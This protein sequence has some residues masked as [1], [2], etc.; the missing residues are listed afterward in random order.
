[1]LQRATRRYAMHQLWASL[2]VGE[3]GVAVP[4]RVEPPDGATLEEVAVDDGIVSLEL[5]YFI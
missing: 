2:H 3:L 1:M 4:P 5:L